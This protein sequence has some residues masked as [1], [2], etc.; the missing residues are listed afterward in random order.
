MNGAAKVCRSSASALG[1]LKR[2]CLTYHKAVITRDQQSIL[3]AA[4]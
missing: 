1:K 4:K 2:F 3:Q